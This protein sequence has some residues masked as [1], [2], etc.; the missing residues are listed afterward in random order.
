MTPQKARALITLVA[1]VLTST[2]VGIFYQPSLG[3]ITAGIMLYI[4]SYRGG[5]YK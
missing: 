2:G 4:D 5:G 1:V 3:V